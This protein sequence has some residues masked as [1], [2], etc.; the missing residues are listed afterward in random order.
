MKKVVMVVNKKGILVTLFC[1]VLSSFVFFVGHKQNVEPKEL[2]KVYLKGEAIGYIENKELLESYIDKA[3]TS[4]KEKYKV[5]KVYPPNELD[6]IKEV[7]YN[8]EAS[9]ESEIYEKIKDLSPFTINGYIITIK[10]IDVITEDKGEVKTDDVELY[11]LDK[12][13]FQKGIEN[14]VAVFISTEDYNN[15]INDTQAEIKDVGSII[16]DLYIKNKIT[17]KEGKISTEEKIFT[18]IEELDKYL[19]FGTTKEQE[20]YVVKD[21]DTISDI[22]YNNKL[23]VEEFLIANPEFTNENNLLYEGQIVNL[24]LINPLFSL[25][26]EDH[27]VELQIQKYDTK[28]EYDENLLA[29]YERVKQEGVD[30][31]IKVTKKVQKSNGEIE[32]AVITNTETVKPS[33]SKIIIKGSKVIPTVGNLN[34]WAWPTNKPYIIT[35]SYGWRWGKLHEGL[36][37]SGTGYGSPIYAAN[38]GVVDKAG[39]T[40]ING[41]YIYINHN[42]GYYTVYAHLASINVKVGQAVSMGQKIGTMGQSGYAFGTHLHFSVFRGYPFVGGYTINPLSLY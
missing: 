3:Q 22:A 42:N 23:S 1:L 6:I 34:V 24:G 31:T 25:I 11:V 29:G 32:S 27:V 12:E 10:G 20:K 40:N 38:N 9:K 5:D 17:I 30:G 4:I 26:E 37:I 41:N 33:I 28:I 39:Y 8:Q 35:S 7:T 2:Y 16:E 14:T 36:D 15:F 18:D 13:L 21:G 19:L